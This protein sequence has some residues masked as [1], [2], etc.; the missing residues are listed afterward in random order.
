MPL[1]DDKQI[2][3]LALGTEPENIDPALIK[4]APTRR[5]AKPM[6]EGLLRYK[7]GTTEVEPCLAESYKVSE[8]GLQY[9]FYL[10]ENVAF[11]DGT[12]LD[13]SD[14]VESFKRLVEI[15]LGP[16]YYYASADSVEALGPMTVRFTL[17]NSDP[18]FLIALPFFMIIS[19]DALEQNDVGG[20]L[21][22]A[23]LSSNEAGSGPFTLTAWEPRQTITVERFDGHWEGWEGPHL[24]KIIFSYVPEAA[25][26]LLLLTEGEV[27]T[28]DYLSADDAVTLSSDPRFVVL[29]APSGSQVYVAL[30]TN[31][32][33]L[34]DKNLRKAIT[35]ALDYDT[36]ATQVMK[37]LQPATNSPLPR[38]YSENLSEL[39]NYKQDMYL[40]R[41]YLSRTQYPT[42]GIKLAFVYVAGY[43]RYRQ[44]GELLRSNLAELNIELELQPQPWATLTK[45]STTP[46]MRPDMLEYAYSSKVPSAWLHL[47]GMYHSDSVGHWSQ[48][49]YT[50]PSID[51]LLDFAKPLTDF[52]VRSRILQDVQRLVIEDQ[53]QI[54]VG[55]R[56]SWKIFSTAVKGY[57]FEP[58]WYQDFN[59]E[60]LYLVE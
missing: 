20:D 45:M 12:S 28:A 17:Q 14:V 37:G 9:T 57:V 6:Y 34:Q 38:T 22:Q 41:E 31:E 47:F 32:G 25:T 13:A 43:E 53:P 8:D 15:G 49:G 48:F 27:H 56:S 19:S 33:P 40:A 52:D 39:S 55:E 58:T 29:S 59:F 23:W 18:D 21:A 42:G 16:S 11:H 24:K 46:D 7:L 60:D 2:F 54:F 50:N 10:R 1:P 5:T 3:I 44:L 26:Q 30:N 51:A 35:Y 36:F 4:D